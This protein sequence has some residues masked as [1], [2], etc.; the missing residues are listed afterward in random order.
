MKRPSQLDHARR[1]DREFKDQQLVV[2]ALRRAGI[3][4]NAQSN[5]LHLSKAQ[6]GKAVAAG[7]QKGC[8]DLMI[9]TPPPNVPEAVGMALEMKVADKAPKTER[10]GR[11]SGAEAHQKEWLEALEA[12]GWHCVVAYGALDA[13]DKLA[14]A[15]YPVK[16]AKTWR[17]VQLKTLEEVA[18]EITPGEPTPL[19]S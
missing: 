14:A 12:V 6:A 15:G 7:L 13:M 1:V 16:A 3:L 2:Y 5:G 8:P 18:L 9:F 19:S 11:F 4:F 10:A 17:G